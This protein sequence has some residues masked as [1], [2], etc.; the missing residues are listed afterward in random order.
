[1]AHRPKERSMALAARSST[2]PPEPTAVQ[3]CTR[4]QPARPAHLA[5]G[6]WPLALNAEVH[7]GS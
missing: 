1:M 2:H 5:L 6:P 7:H 3:Q 4:A